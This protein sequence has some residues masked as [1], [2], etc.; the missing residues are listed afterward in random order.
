M[1]KKIVIGIVGNERNIDV[2]GAKRILNEYRI[3]FDIISKNFLS[4]QIIKYPLLLFPSEDSLRYCQFDDLSIFL[5]NGGNLIICGLVSKKNEHL[6]K[7]NIKGNIKHSKLKLKLE[8]NHPIVNNIANREIRINV[9]AT[10]IDK[11]E[12]Y[13]IIGKFIYDDYEYPGLIISKQK[14]IICV[15]F[16]IYKQVILWENEK[17]VNTQERSLLNDFLI[18]WYDIFPQKLKKT[19]KIYVR[20]IKNQISKNKTMYTNFPFENSSDTIRLLIFN[21]ILLYSL[22]SFELLPIINKWPN[23]YKAAM[24]ITHDIDTNIDYNVGFPRLLEIEEKYDIKTTW[25]FVANSSEYSINSQLLSKLILKNYEVAC[26][27]LYHDLLSDKISSDEREDRLI[28]SKSKLESMLDDYKVNGY[29]SPGLTRTEDLWFLLE[30]SGYKY[31]MSFPD[32]DHYTLSRYGMGVSSHVPYNP[33]CKIEDEYKELEILE[34]PLAAL[35]EANLFFDLHLDEKEAIKIWIKKAEYIIRDGGLVVFLFHPS[36][37]IA[38]SKAEMYESLIRFFINKNDLWITT[39]NT[40]AEWWNKR[41]NVDILF[42]YQRKNEWKIKIC[43]SG[44][45][46][47][48][49]LTLAIYLKN[50]KKLRI[51]KGD[52]EN[53]SVKKF[54][55][56]DVYYLTIRSVEEIS[57]KILIVAIEN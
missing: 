54:K 13:E 9:E 17:Y 8:N 15:P 37:F 12:E 34:L 50:N 39:S 43:N 14:N 32:N 33:I 7:I 47:I 41:K 26:H 2:V 22:D 57:Y 56:H 46:P 42:E 20:G 3:P 52:V 45:K 36:L 28:E 30:K 5:K 11:C 38:K 40:I 44:K 53:T 55:W 51:K 10:L 25:N 23:N 21:S 1:F 29:R 16:E 35:Q 49:Y 24:A 48:E 27:G 19:F 6:L 18:K 4:N 31:D